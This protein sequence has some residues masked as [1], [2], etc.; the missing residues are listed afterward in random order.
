MSIG[1]LGTKIHWYTLLFIDENAF[2]DDGNFVQG[3]MSVVPVLY[4]CRTRHFQQ[5][6]W[7]QMSWH[8]T[9][10]SHRYPEWW[11]DN[12]RHVPFKVPLTLTNQWVVQERHNSSGLTMELRLSCTN[13]SKC[14]LGF[15]R[16]PFPMRSI[17]YPR[18][19]YWWV[20]TFNFYVITHPYPNFNGCLVTEPLIWRHG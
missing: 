19:G 8:Q 2:E 6:Q 16:Q 14:W 7:L 15:I 3:E 13:P 5:W 12:Y 17:E 18:L 11:L 20:I 10:L 4:K 9:V 1:P